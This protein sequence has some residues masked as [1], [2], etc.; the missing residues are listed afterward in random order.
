MAHHRRDGEFQQ[1][2]F[3]EMTKVKITTCGQYV[4]LPLRGSLA[5][6]QCAKM[7]AVKEYVAWILTDGGALDVASTVF[8]FTSFL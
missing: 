2:Q 3:Y 4:L 7:R 1:L 6:G 5:L 8:L